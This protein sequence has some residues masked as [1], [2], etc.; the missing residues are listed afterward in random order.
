[1]LSLH[2]FYLIIHLICASIWVGGHL[3][4][5]IGYL[6]KALKKKEFSYIQNFEKIYEPIG[7]PCLILLIIT[8]VLMAYDFNIGI[9]D[10]FSFENAMEK[11][12]S[13]KIIGVIVTICFAISA[14]VRVLPQLAKGKIEKL[15]EMGL[16]IIGVTFISVILLILGSYIHYDLA[17]FD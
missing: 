5:A 7:M 8:G 6:P 15:P 2:H 17:A 12:I 14:Q 16:H 11:I 13:L 10:W 1:M 3:I 4:L 9:S